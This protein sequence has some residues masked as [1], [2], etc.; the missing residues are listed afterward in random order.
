MVSQT[1]NGEEDMSDSEI[2]ARLVKQIATKNLLLKSNQEKL[3]G[4]HNAIY[5]KE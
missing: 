2:I 1:K 4:S 3:S 5:N